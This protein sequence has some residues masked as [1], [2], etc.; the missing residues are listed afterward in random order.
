VAGYKHKSGGVFRPTAKTALLRF[1]KGNVA[2]AGE[3]GLS[4]LKIAV[5]DGNVDADAVSR[6]RLKQI[7]RVEVVVKLIPF[8]RDYL[9]V[10]L[11]LV[12]CLDGIGRAKK[13]GR[14]ILDLIGDPDLIGHEVHGLVRLT[15]IIV[16]P[17]LSD[18]RHVADDL[19]NRW[20]FDSV[21]AIRGPKV[22]IALMVKEVSVACFRGY[23]SAG[24]KDPGF[25]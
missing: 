25:Q 12:N 19:G 11:Y 20:N 1:S 3:E 4:F 23:G 21:K 18:Q 22:K 7:D 10:D 6:L 14:R 24:S 17:I 5:L 2:I 9:S 13:D 15:D 16:D 8:G